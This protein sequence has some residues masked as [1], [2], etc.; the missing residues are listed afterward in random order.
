VV[1]YGNCEAMTHAAIATLLP[2]FARTDSPAALGSAFRIHRDNTYSPVWDEGHTGP[3]VWIARE[4]P[5][6][7]EIRADEEESF[8]NPARYASV[9]DVMRLEARIVFWYPLRIPFADWV[10]T[11]MFLAQL[12]LRE[13]T[14][15]DPIQ[16][17]HN[18]RWRQGMA[19]SL[20]AAI[21]QELLE[22][23]DREEYVFPLQANYS[24]RMMTP[25]RRQFFEEQNCSP[26]PQT[27]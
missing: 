5:L 4:R 18:A 3:I 11:R 14:A 1:K 13:Y 8:D 10:L 22:R 17:V 23:V 16:P 27:L 6:R 7:G 19:T 15:V 2:S 26:T 21:R 9:S 12:G 20:E 24:M 25:A